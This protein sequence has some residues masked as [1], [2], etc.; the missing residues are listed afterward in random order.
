MIVKNIRRALD[1]RSLAE[2]GI[3]VYGLSD[4][5]TNRVLYVGKGGGK[6]EDDTGNLRV[7][8]H[9]REAEQ[10]LERTVKDPLAQSSAKCLAIHAVWER[11]EDVRVSFYRRRL[12]D[13]REAFHVEAAVIAA[14]TESSQGSTANANSGMHLDDHGALTL[15]EVVDCGAPPVNPPVAVRVLLFNIATSLSKRKSRTPSDVYECT[16]YAWARL[17]KPATDIIAIGY[18]GNISRGGFVNPQ[19]H[20]EDD[21]RLSFTAEKSSWLDQEHPLVG[22]SFNAVLQLT[23]WRLRNGVIGVEFDGAGQFRIFRGASTEVAKRWYT[24]V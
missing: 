11:G 3:H 16:R 1:E 20:K 14:L 9:F 17:G 7:F 4:P 22:H 5:L 19:W 2:L 10:E 23:P 6:F 24:C 21:G 15:S 8:S 12:R 18:S 13:E